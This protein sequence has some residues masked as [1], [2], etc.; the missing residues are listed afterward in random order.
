MTI[1]ETHC[2]M[3][4]YRK[5]E[6]VPEFSYRTYDFVEKPSDDYFCPVTKKFLLDPKQL[7]CCGE[8]I[9]QEGFQKVKSQRGTPKCPKCDKVDFQVVDC[10]FFKK[11]FVNK[12]KIRCQY[13]IRGCKW[14]EEVGEYDRHLR[15]KRSD[16]W[17]AHPTAQYGRAQV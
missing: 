17:D 16:R 14:I 12:V 2:N 6:F 11:R 3:K 4:A 7:T 15:D 13:K 10:M 1:Y 9:S 8:H 5:Y